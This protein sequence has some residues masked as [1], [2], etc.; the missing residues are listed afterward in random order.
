MKYHLETT[1]LIDWHRKSPRVAPFR[2]EILAGLHEISID[3]V[4]ETEYFAIPILTRA[5]EISFASLAILATRLPFTSDAARLAAS[6][7][8]RMDRPQRRRHFND[9]LIAAVAM[10]NGA[11]LLTG[12]KKT[13]RVFPIRARV[14]S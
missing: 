8:A 12:D 11:I 6:W 1:F 4:A 13:D 5:R 14:Y 7:L 3:P 9:A 2:A 10:T